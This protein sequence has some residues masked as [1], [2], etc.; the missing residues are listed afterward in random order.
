MA[1][2]RRRIGLA[3]VVFVDDLALFVRNGSYCHRSFSLSS[4]VKSLAA[5]V[6]GQAEHVQR[7]ES[8]KRLFVEGRENGVGGFHGD[9]G[10]IASVRS[11]SSTS[12]GTKKRWCRS[13]KSS[14][15][16]AARDVAGMTQ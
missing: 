11:A 14:S 13:R 4:R 15:A 12:S 7:G 2:R 5:E 9:Q 1:F 8:G 6:S 10:N 3:I 16:L